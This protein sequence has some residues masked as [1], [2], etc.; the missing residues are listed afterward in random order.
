MEKRI[1]FFNRIIAFAGALIFFFLFCSC[2]KKELAATVQRTYYIFDTQAILRLNSAESGAETEEIFSAAEQILKETE[3]SL[4]GE[5]SPVA[6]FN[7]AEAGERVRLDER[8]Y[9]ALNLA[10]EMHGVTNGLYNPGVYYSVDL[11]GFTPRFKNYAGCVAPYD[12]AENSILPEEKYITAFC[13]L[14]AHFPD[15]KTEQS[16]GE[17]YAIKPADAYAEVDGERYTLQIDLGG[18]GKGIAADKVSELMSEKGIRYGYFSFGSS[19]LYVA[20]RSESTADWT[21][22]FNNPRPS[23]V[24]GTYFSVGLSDC[25]VSTS[26]DYENYYETDGVRYSHIID[27][28]TGAPAQGG[29]MSASVIGGTAA[30]GDALT[31]ALLAM[32]YPSAISFVN[33]KLTDKKVIISYADE[34]GYK[35][36]ANFEG[37]LTDPRFKQDYKAENGRMVPRSFWDKYASVIVVCA[38]L[39]LAV[40]AFGV[41]IRKKRGRKNVS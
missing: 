8:A 37:K 6:A 34:G 27:P 2:D 14:A 18:I 22:Y 3:T 33:E 5:N 12:R 10:L 20:K 38:V 13:A 40:L 24:S 15:I 32:D 9:N 41:V 21:V 23:G 25:A 1:G 11:W 7:R 36:A 31:T 35:V 19:S 30:E 4:N 29:V 16:E 28:R 26:G 39:A 17:Y